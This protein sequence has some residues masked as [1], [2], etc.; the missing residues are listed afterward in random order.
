MTF[1]NQTIRPKTWHKKKHQIENKQQITHK[2]P[3]LLPRRQL[4]LRQVERLQA[5]EP[6]HLLVPVHRTGGCYVGYVRN[7]VV[8]GVQLLQ[9]RGPRPKD[10]HL[11]PSS[12]VKRKKAKRVN[13]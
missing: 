7:V 4:R 3:H 2:Y 5:A 8:R 9:R 11:R 10:G 1:P 13:K 12:A 6:V